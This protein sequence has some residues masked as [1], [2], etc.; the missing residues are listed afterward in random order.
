M[1]SSTAGEAGKA[2]LEAQ[3][4]LSPQ[5]PPDAREQHKLPSKGAALSLSLP[6]SL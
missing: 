2:P 3:S 4:R 5:L 1:A 6:P